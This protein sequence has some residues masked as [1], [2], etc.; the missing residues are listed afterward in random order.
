M[1]EAGIIFWVEKSECV[2]PVVISL[3]KDTTQIRIC[4]DFCCLNAVTIKDPFSISFTDSI[5]KEVGGHEI[6]SF[7]DGFSRY[8]QIYVVE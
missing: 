3:R 4:I 8:N 5:L 6:Y 2:S 1:L 7:M